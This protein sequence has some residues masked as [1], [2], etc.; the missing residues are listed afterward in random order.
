MSEA[1]VRQLATSIGNLGV[2]AIITGIAGPLVSRGVL[3]TF[4]TIM[5]SLFGVMLVVVAV[6]V[7]E[8]A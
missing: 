1:Q 2:G 7:A 4:P 3:E 5:W 8:G 6:I